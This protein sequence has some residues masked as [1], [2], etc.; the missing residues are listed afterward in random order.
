M[1]GSR[2]PSGTQLILCV[3]AVLVAFL[4]GH[5]SGAE[6]AGEAGRRRIEKMSPAQKERLRRLHERFLSFEPAERQR[7]RELHRRLHR[8][9]D[10]SQLRRVL[11]GYCQWL[12]S[13]P[14]YRRAELLEMEPQK[15]IERIKEIRKE[16]AKRLKPEDMEGIL[17]W[18]RQYAAKY[19]TRIL[20][21]ILEAIPESRRERMAKFSP[22]MRQRVAMWSVMWKWGPKPRSG[23]F[24]PR[25][26]EDLATLRS[27]LSQDA[28]TRLAQKPSSEQWQIV[29][30]WARD[31]VRHYFSSR[32]SE[33]S[34]L[35][36]D[37]EQ[38]LDY[39]FEHELSDE[40]Q[41]YL[42]S[43]PS[44]EMQRALRRMYLMQFRPPGPP[45]GPRRPTRPEGPGMRGPERPYS[46]QHRPGP[47]PESSPGSRGPRQR[48]DMRPR[49]ESR[50]NH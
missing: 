16:Q 26:D 5:V 48:P 10:A 50:R 31:A 17:R 46:G 39:F 40:R 45:R 41:D 8:E 4:L 29:A 11:D 28:R 1:M 42:L 27:N 20:E 30:S 43:L 38:E 33:G 37:L 36:A 21:R 9:E 19:E 32:G 24:P 44:D 7:I 3:F 2:R 13:L 25:T 49:G 14:P 47:R 12:K 35:S 34:S 15:R 23:D 18:M 22:A 6:D